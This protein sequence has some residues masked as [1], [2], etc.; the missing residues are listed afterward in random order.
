MDKR[1]IFLSSTS[2]DL[3]EHRMAAAEACRRMGYD[4]ISMEEWPALDAKPESACLSKVDLADIYVGIYAFRYGW[5]PNGKDVSI[6]ELEYERAVENKLGRLLFFVNEEEPWPPAL[7]DK[8]EAAE[9]LQAFKMRIA[10][11]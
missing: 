10:S 8:G 11:E 9:K 7:V 3:T 5:I 2:I 4:V 1:K 6:T